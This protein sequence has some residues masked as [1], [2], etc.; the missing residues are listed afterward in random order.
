MQNSTIKQGAINYI[1]HFTN[2][3]LLKK[4]FGL[5]QGKLAFNKSATYADD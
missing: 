2:C 4:S 3:N 5:F 1:F